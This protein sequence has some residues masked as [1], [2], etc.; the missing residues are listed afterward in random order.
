[1][2]PILAAAM[3]LRGDDS[4]GVTD[5]YHLYKHTGSI[6]SNFEDHRCETPT[7]HTR[8]A[9][10]GAISERNA[11]PFEYISEEQGLVVVGMHNGHL[12]NHEE[13]K[14]KYLDHRKEFEVDSE[15]IFAQLAER[16]PTGEIHG[17]GAVVWYEYPI[18]RPKERRR[19]ITT[20]NNTAMNIIRLSTGEMVFASTCEAIRIAARFAGVDLVSH[21]KVVNKMKYELMENG[22]IKSHG[23]M[24]WDERPP[25]VINHSRHRSHAHWYGNGNGE[26][27]RNHGA[28]PKDFGTTPS[29]DS[30][31]LAARS[32]RESAR[33]FQ[34]QTSTCKAWGCYNIT[35]EDELMCSRCLQRIVSKYCGDGAGAVVGGTRREVGRTTLSEPVKIYPP[36]TA[37]V[38]PQKVWNG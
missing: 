18:G 32:A 7:F 24:E 15:H 2:V 38:P 33:T 11:H 10:V 8:G 21:V 12:H 4:W 19:F 26:T 6:L 9:S 17:Y 22:V 25:V 27:P 36:G 29:T 31:S 20:F 13:L 34:D 3:E 37:I 14:T 5:G 16:L 35:T 1:M 30:S 28:S 23:L